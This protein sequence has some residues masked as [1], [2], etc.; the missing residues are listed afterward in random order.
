MIRLHHESLICTYNSPGACSALLG[1]WRNGAVLKACH[2]YNLYVKGHIPRVHGL[3]QNGT[4][5]ENMAIYVC[6]P[7]SPDQKVI[8]GIPATCER[9]EIGDAASGKS[10][11]RLWLHVVH[12]AIPL[13]RGTSKRAEKSSVACR[14]EPQNETSAFDRPSTLLESASQMRSMKLLAAPRF[15]RLVRVP[16]GRG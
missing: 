9:T 8:V 2:M 4:L 6:F 10:H 5:H 3:R 13:I 7:S 15:S 11:V 12:S 14:I 16:W 1:E